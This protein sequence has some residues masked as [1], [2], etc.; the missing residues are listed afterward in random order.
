[1]HRCWIALAAPV[2]G[3]MCGAGTGA[4][5]SWRYV[6]QGCAVSAPTLALR[7]G[8]LS[9]EGGTQTSDWAQLLGLCGRRRAQRPGK[10]KGRAQKSVD[11][12]SKNGVLAQDSPL[13]EVDTAIAAKEAEVQELLQELDESTA[14]HSDGEEG[15]EEESEG[16]DLAVK[17]APLTREELEELLA[18]LVARHPEV[19]ESVLELARRPFDV[20]AIP[21]R[22]HQLSL[23]KASPEEFAE[24]MT[25]LASKA[26]AYAEAGDMTNARAM[27]EAL[28]RA[29]AAAHPSPD[30]EGHLAGFW[31]D[32]EST[33]DAVCRQ[34]GGKDAK[35]HQALR[36]HLTRMQT[37][38]SGY[39]PLFSDALRSLRRADARAAA[40]RRGRGQTRGDDF[41]GINRIGKTAKKAR[42][43]IPARSATA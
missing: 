36:T 25:P 8:G 39:G 10:R 23:A 11:A 2:L 29:V 22:V 24:E 21:Y 19:G 3:L 7:G 35:A 9:A 43:V 28:T 41:F 16:I 12:A 38:L 5:G 18:R 33:W 15:E 13:D 26:H 40:A 31:P 34:V 6:A 37:A 30:A 1:M 42:H 32:V 14:A 17:L 27:A 20:G 4:A